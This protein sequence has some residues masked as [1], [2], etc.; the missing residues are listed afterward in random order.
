MEFEYKTERELRAQLTPEQ[1]KQAMEYIRKMESEDRVLIEDEDGAMFG[2]P[3]SVYEASLKKSREQ[4]AEASIKEP[5]LVDMGPDIPC[6]VCGGRVK[7]ELQWS[8]FGK[9][10]FAVCFCEKVEKHKH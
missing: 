3:V 2:M 1:L 5:P 10:F 8:N 9:E 6:P 7:K 4:K